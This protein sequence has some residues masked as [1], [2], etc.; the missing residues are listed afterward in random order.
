MYFLVPVAAGGVKEKQCRSGKFLR[1]RVLVHELSDA[2]QG[3]VPGKV[4]APYFELGQKFFDFIFSPSE[5]DTGSPF[6]DV[7]FLGEALGIVGV[8][9]C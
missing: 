2:V 6:D 8:F 3:Y 4:A 9:E 1:K 5:D 7:H